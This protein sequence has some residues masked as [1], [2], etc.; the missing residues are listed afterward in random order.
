MDN[1]YL[2]RVGSTSNILGR[3]AR[4]YKSSE[5]REKGCNFASVYGVTEDDAKAI[6]EAGTAAGFRGTV[7]S[8]RLW[9]D[10]DN[11]Q[12]A[13]LGRLRLKE[14]GLDHVVYTTGGRGCH[15]GILRNNPPS[16]VLPLQDKLWVS[17][18]LPG[19]DLG[20]YWHLHLIRL[21]GAV[22][23]RTGLSKRV[24]YRAEGRELVLPPYDPDRG[25]HNDKPVGRV[26]RRESLFQV[27]E[28]ASKLGIRALDGDRHKHLVSLVR[29]LSD[30]K[31]VSV[32]E[33]MWMLV[34]VNRGFSEPKPQEELDRLVKWAFE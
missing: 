13:T 20:L 12:A 25:V 29:E 14:M 32:D 9:V 28:I 31:D 18:N 10:F 5:L 11:E 34:E 8:Q 23:D 3:P 6:E 21:P 27:W 19:A 4:M 24:L 2:Y 26:E 30:R 17:E 7:W 22:H 15:I 33:A 16:H 1:R